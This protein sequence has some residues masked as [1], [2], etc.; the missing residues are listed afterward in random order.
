[1]IAAICWFATQPVGSM[2]PPPPG[3]HES[4]AGEALLFVPSL[5]ILIA[6]VP[7]V[8]AVL[9]YAVLAAGIGVLTRNKRLDEGAWL[10]APAMPAVAGAG[11]YLYFMWPQLLPV[12]R[13]MSSSAFDILLIMTMLGMLG[14]A[15]LVARQYWRTAVSAAMF[16]G[17]VVV[18]RLYFQWPDP[19]S[20]GAG[21]MLGA[22]VL[23]ALS[24]LA[25]RRKDHWNA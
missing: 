12:A 2:P 24:A 3:G 18:L 6:V 25:P 22:L 11:A 7:F 17:A 23:W 1:M 4:G 13:W 16:V 9:I 8:L 20:F 21:A 5:I 15:I 14:I 19:W 10:V